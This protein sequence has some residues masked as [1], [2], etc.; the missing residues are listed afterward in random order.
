MMLL[1][2]EG[3]N[4]SF[5]KLLEQLIILN[6]INLEFPTSNNQFASIFYKVR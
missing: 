3:I 1:L 6:R 5:V 4:D 2:G